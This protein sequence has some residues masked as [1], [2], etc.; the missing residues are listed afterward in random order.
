MRFNPIVLPDETL[1]RVLGTR[2]ETR[3]LKR[4]T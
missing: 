4:V 1:A 3:D 2:C